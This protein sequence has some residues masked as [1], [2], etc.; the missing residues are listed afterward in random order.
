MPISVAME[1]AAG[2]PMSMSAVRR[3]GGAVT[4]SPHCPAASGRPSCSDQHCRTVPPAALRHCPTC[5][6]ATLFHLQHCRTVLAGR[7]SSPD[8]SCAAGG[9]RCT[10][11]LLLPANRFSVYCSTTASGGAE[12]GRE[13]G[14]EELCSA[15]LPDIIL[16]AILCQSNSKPPLQ[17]T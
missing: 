7:L 5:R 11:A 17:C 15:A 6:S 9:P 2:S 8:C 10:Y 13:T 12:P 4:W 3:R 1:T 14:E 16:V